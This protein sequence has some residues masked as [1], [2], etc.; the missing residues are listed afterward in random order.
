M[1]HT[2]YITFNYLSKE[3]FEDLIALETTHKNPDKPYYYNTSLS[4]EGITFIKFHKVNKLN[5]KSRC[6]GMK[7]N[8]LRLIE[9]KDRINTL[10]PK[11]VAKMADKFNKVIK[12]L[13]KDLPDFYEWTT[14]RIDYCINIKTPHVK[15]YIKLFQS[16]NIPRFFAIPLDKNK[17]LR[18]RVGSLYYTNKSTNI[19][20]YD[21]QDEL[22]N[23]QAQD[24][25]KKSTSF[26][27][28]EH[29]KQSENILRLEV[30]C[31]Q[32]KTNYLKCKY[33][34]DTKHIKYFLNADMSR[35]AIEKAYKDCIG[36]GNFFTLKTARK[37]V[38]NLDN[39][40]QKTKD[41][42]QEIL[43]NVAISRGVY[44]Y[45]SKLSDQERLTKIRQIRNL[46]RYGINPITIPKDMGIK[47]SLNKYQ[48]NLPSLI[49]DI[50]NYFARLNLRQV[51]KEIKMDADITSYKEI[52]DLEFTQNIDNP[53]F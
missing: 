34:L 24:I 42:Y 44:N 47:D 29:I 25:S 18:H 14:N 53:I 10:T 4:K 26:I 39:I 22:K 33:D 9:K 35:H 28:D 15:E 31:K 8:F 21:K 1:V 2:G 20:F 43:Q 49:C 46:N 7:I 45:L 41:T 23:Q 48:D 6:V 27:T 5:F 37:L 51:Y 16:G 3:I 19:N 50:N 38:Q 13:H 40:T 12:T 32:G 30:Q 36:Y 11:K 17:H 52:Q